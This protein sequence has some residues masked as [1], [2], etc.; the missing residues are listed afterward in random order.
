ML[1]ELGLGFVRLVAKFSLLEKNPGVTERK[2]HRIAS[3]G[4][5][6]EWI[7]IPASPNAEFQWLKGPFC[8][9]TGTVET[10]LWSILYMVGSKVSRFRQVGW[11]AASEAAIVPCDLRQAS[12]CLWDVTACPCAGACS[13]KSCTGHSVA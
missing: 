12:Y 2:S 7:A 3:Q 8:S 5:R 10:P 9:K 6:T 1:P 11:A 13:S 4:R